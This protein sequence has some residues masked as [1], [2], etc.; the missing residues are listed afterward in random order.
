MLL[1]SLLTGLALAAAPALAIPPPIF[2]F[3]DSDNHTELTV[4]YTFNGNTT[5][6]QEAM[7]F[8]NNITQQ[9][10]QLSL[11]AA[12]YQSVADYTG[13]YTLIMVDPDASTPEQPT[14]RFF[15]HWLAPNTTQSSS[16][17]DLRQLT[18]P[19]STFVPYLP[20]TP[21][22]TSSAHRYIV[23]AFQQ[24]DSFVVPAA[25]AGLFTGGG[26][27]QQQQ[28]SRASFN[29]T[30]FIAAAGLGRPAAAE[31]FYVNRQAQ[32]PGDFVALAGGVYPG[33]NGAAVF[34]DSA[35]AGGNATATS[36]ATPT[37][38]GAG[39]AATATAGAMGGWL[40]R[41]SVWEGWLGLMVC[42]IVALL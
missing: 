16:S 26:Q 35:S 17:D 25:Y 39:A 12:L 2:G 19:N 3:P 14:R 40:G 42:G 31:Y 28:Q 13:Q 18:I 24:P 21:P 41:A 10:P 27:Q 20:P 29:L 8:G 33:G 36:G 9:Q 23:Y 37:G 38:T 34:E 32:V 6:V 11:N 7:L 22:E 4:A 30:D 1:R 5:T 15:L